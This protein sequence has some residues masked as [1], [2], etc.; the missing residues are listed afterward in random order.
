MESTAASGR[1]KCRSPRLPI[2]ITFDDPRELAGEKISHNSIFFS[3]LKFQRILSEFP[4]LLHAKVM[5]IIAYFIVLNVFAD[6]ERTKRANQ[7]TR[8]PAVVHVSLH[9][10]NWAAWSFLY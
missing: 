3:W 10:R 2:N 7:L 5:R 4:T 9:R 8:K 6:E 1:T